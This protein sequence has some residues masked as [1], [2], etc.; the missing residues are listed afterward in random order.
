[1]KTKKKI[2]SNKQTPASK[3][4]LIWLILLL[5]F[6]A[7]VFVVYLLKDYNPVL[8]KEAEGFTNLKADFLQIQK[9]FNRVD[10]GWQYAEGCRGKG[11]VY[12]DNEASSCRLI[13]FTK[14]TLTLKDLRKNFNQYL[15]ATIQSDKFTQKS[16][17]CTVP[18]STS[19]ASD[20]TVLRVADLVSNSFLGSTCEISETLSADKTQGGI[21]L[22]CNH[23]SHYFRYRRYDR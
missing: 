11:G 19:V 8:Q 9:I 5:V 17:V 16:A 3:P 4:R 13:L 7:I 15:T 22:E 12:N 18:W 10:Q 14:E 1:M 2:A 6:A 20:K 21:L 23:P